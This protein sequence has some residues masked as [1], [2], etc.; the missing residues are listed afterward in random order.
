MQSLDNELYEVQLS[1]KTIVEDLP[2]QIGFFILQTAK[3]RMLEFHFDFLHNYFDISKI[4]LI[5]MDTDSSY[6]A[7][8]APSLE[9][10][11]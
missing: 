11:F 6:F 9:H 7:I 2:V 1:K 10:I 4:R 8:A 3:L 5:Q